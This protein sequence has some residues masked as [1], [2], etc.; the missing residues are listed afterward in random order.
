[1]CVSDDVYVRVSMWSYARVC[2]CERIRAFVVVNV[3]VHV[4]FGRIHA[5]VV[6]GICVRVFEDY[7]YAYTC[8]CR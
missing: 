8:V 5:C 4:L 1:M 7:V 3:C 2:W 6:V